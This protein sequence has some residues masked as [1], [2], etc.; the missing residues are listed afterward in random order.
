MWFGIIHHVCGEHEWDDGQCA[1]GPLT[2][3]E[4]DKTCIDKASKAARELRKIVF[5][6]EWLKSMEYYVYFRYNMDC[7]LCNVVD[8]MLTKHT[9]F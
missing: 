3:I 4:G 9:M 8:L 2:E 6:K 5:Y 7:I 1:H